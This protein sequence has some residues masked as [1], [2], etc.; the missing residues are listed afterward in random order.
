MFN[1]L[2]LKNFD[3]R[4]VYNRYAV[5]VTVLSTLS[6][7]VAYNVAVV[8]QEWVSPTIAGVLSLTAIKSTF[9]DTVQESIKQ[10]VG[11][12]VGALVG[13]FFISWFGF[14]SLTLAII[15]VFAF[16]L[17]WLL[18]LKAEGGLVIAAMVLL[19]NGPLL[20][21]F[22]NIEQRIAGVL[23]GSLCALIASMF[24]IPANPHKVI[25]KSSVDASRETYRLMKSISRKFSSFEV[26]KMKEAKLWLANINYILSDI[27]VDREKIDVIFTDAKWSPLLSKQDVENV[28]RQVKIVKRNAE[29]LRS[30]IDSIVHHLDNGII[31]QEKVSKDIGKLLFETAEAIKKQNKLAV[32]V[33]AEFLDVEDVSMMN[34]RK[35]KVANEMKKI[36]DTETLLLSGT[37]LHEVTKIRNS[38]T[39]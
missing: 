32:D 14:N 5:R 30:I 15:I 19:V 2:S 10:V 36:D 13:M 27:N 7:L 29:A 35:S 8:F 34:E 31:M 23:L 38:I 11:T 6:A 18:R 39:G 4:K 20:N 17:G 26:I 28:V 22:Q 16:I 24:I 21:D 12:T 33:P 37:L 3:A 25:L 9:H 1:R